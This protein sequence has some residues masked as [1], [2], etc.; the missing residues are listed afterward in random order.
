[1]PGLIIFALLRGYSPLHAVLHGL[2]LASLAVLAMAAGRRRR[3]AS[4]VVSFGLITSSALLVHTWGG[5]IEA[6]F[7]FFVMIALL[8]LYEDWLPFLLAAAYV[9][10]HHGL[11]GAL[12]PAS[13]YNHPDAAAHPWK[14]AAIHGAFVTAAGV[15]SVTAWRL[16]ENVR[17]EMLAAYGRAR[18]S[19]ERFKSAFDE[20]PIGMALS[21]IG[22]EDAGRFVQVNR[23]LCKLLGYSADELVGSH[24]ERI[25]HPADRTGSKDL[26]QQVLDGTRSSFQVEK[27]YVHAEGHT[28]WGLLNLS[29][30]HD[31]HGKPHHA[32]A[33]IE[34]I[35]ERKLAVQ[36]VLQSRHQLAEAQK[37]AHIG[38]YEWDIA[39]NQLIWS[40]E[41]FR[42]FGLEP[43]DWEPSYEG[44]IERVHPDQRT[45]VNDVIQASVAS[46]ERLHDEYS[47]TRPNGEQRVI[48]TYGEVVLGEDGEAIKLVGTAQDVTEKR[49]VEQQLQLQREAEHEL[50]SRS[51]FL[52]RISHEL[53]TP[54]NAIL[55]FA[56]VLELG[57]LDPDEQQSVKQILKGGTHLLEL[58]NEVLEMSRVDSGNMSVSLESVSIA[59][60]VTDAL[61]LVGPMAS[62]H[63]VTL[64]NG[65]DEQGGR[66]ALADKQRLKQVMLNLLSNGIKYNQE[67][68]SVTVSLEDVPDERVLLMVRDT[69]RGIPESKLA[70]VFVPFDRL[71]AEQTSIEGTGL[72]LTLSKLLVEAMGG[73]LSVESEP[74][75]GSTFMVGLPAS[76]AV[77]VGAV[78]NRG[79]GSLA[80]IGSSAPVDATILYVED[81]LSNFKLVDRLLSQRSTV[82]LLTA[83][84]GSLGLELARQHHPD[85]ILLDLHLPVM[86]GREVL[87]RLKEDPA[88]SEIPV[89]V[90]SADATTS[91]V[92]QLLGAGAAAFITKPLDVKR[93]MAVVEDAL[94]ER[95]AA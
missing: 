1:V 18:E 53:R 37:L 51:E 23:A 74:W 89:V 48:E 15:A 63:G 3:F 59:E 83:M 44:F 92:E 91:S 19:E 84:E 72:G 21:S 47:V 12:D 75:V 13:V 85:L 42:I 43:G 35:N 9:V 8:A 11:M 66:H 94:R 67:G 6:H 25:T 56:Q 57:D 38:S 33:Q 60:I 26:Y 49:R 39:T 2:P 46:R 32:I 20:A 10:V 55:G 54:L 22:A 90:V 28:V 31:E 86:D 30:V 62:Q 70:Q 68:G 78:S 80:A 95:I 87:R 61:D 69:G 93:F 81:N 82:R 41:L 65:L 77:A 24:F 88:T 16:N 79:N 34:D 4:A 45:H 71:G 64:H 52:S 36:A 50:Q 17:A 5:V 27:R 7:H 73:T 14:W 29:L 58:I 76:E 40:D